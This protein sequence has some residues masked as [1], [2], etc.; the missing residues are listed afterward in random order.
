ML[1][2]WGMVGRAITIIRE[3]T[4]G[5]VRDALDGDKIITGIHR[6]KVTQLLA[7]CVTKES[8]YTHRRDILWSGWPTHVHQSLI[9]YPL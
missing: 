7:T 6:L 4:N 8:P 1:V 3:S 2:L 5:D 9:S